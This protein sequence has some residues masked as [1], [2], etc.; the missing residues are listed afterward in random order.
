M[1]T[2][3]VQKQ[4]KLISLIP[5][6]DLRVIICIR[7]GLQTQRHFLITIYYILRLFVFLKKISI[8]SGNLH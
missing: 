6:H 7:L 2:E 3:T 8:I 1:Q 4:L 5:Y